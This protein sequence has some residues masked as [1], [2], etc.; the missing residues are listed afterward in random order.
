MNNHQKKN[1]FL[2]NVATVGLL[3]AALIGAARAI[4][5]LPSD[6]GGQAIQ[7]LTRAAG[8]LPVS[9]QLMR[10]NRGDHATFLRVKLSFDR[11]DQAPK[12]EVL[13]NTVNEAVHDEVLKYLAS[14]R[15]PCLGSQ[16]VVAIQEFHFS[17]LGTAEGKPLRAAALTSDLVRNCLVMPKRN[18][19]A[20][21]LGPKYAGAI[22]KIFI[23]ASFDGDGQVGPQTKIIYSDAPGA[24]ENEILAYLA[25]YRMPCR[26][27]GD[28]PFAFRQRFLFSYDGTKP[29]HFKTSELSL[30]QFLGSV[31]G[32]QERPAFFDFASMACPFQVEWTAMRPV[33]SN[34]VRELGSS[35]PNRAEFLAWLR[36]MELTLNP[37]L[38]KQL[39]G[40]T[41]VIDVPCGKIDL[42]PSPL[43]V[44]PSLT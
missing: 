18:P 35:D 38:T 4:T 31:Q 22:A 44:T 29:A 8:P 19:D 41:L 34:G 27:S 30:K 7:C 32:W 17:P 11:P 9:E 20:P 5:V 6:E 26:N 14:Y 12:V 3:W 1:G 37:K 24:L 43:P 40:E 10:E 21:N 25:D 39:L 13:A 42:Q 36:N 2:R 28:K 33:E 16:A 15:L 23:Q